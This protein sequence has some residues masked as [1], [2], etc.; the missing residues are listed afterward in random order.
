[1]CRSDGK[2]QIEKCLRCKLPECKPSCCGI[3]ADLRESQR[4]YRRKKEAEKCKK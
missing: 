4:R 3:E 2:E 1:M